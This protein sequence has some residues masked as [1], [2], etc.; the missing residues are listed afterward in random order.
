[1]PNS[2]SVDLSDWRVQFT[3]TQKGTGNPVFITASGRWTNGDAIEFVMPSPDALLLNAAF[4]AYSRFIEYRKVIVIPDSGKVVKNTVNVFDCMQ[5]Y[6]ECVV[7]SFTSI[8]ISCNLHIQ[9]SDKLEILEK[10]ATE[11]YQGEQIERWVHL[12]KKIEFVA[13]KLGAK[14]DKGATVWSDYK[15][16][17][18]M[19]DRVVHLKNTDRESHS[20]DDDR[21]WSFAFSR[22]PLH[23]CDVAIRVLN[24]LY[25]NAEAPPWLKKANDIHN[26]THCT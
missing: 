20:P 24:T 19:R 10:R 13:R 6:L 22:T 17:A 9:A 23:P 5:A 15:R 21:I 12:D 1:V 16:L 11:T 25:A 18:S 14:I 4:L 2:V 8:E 26:N 3:G 7:S